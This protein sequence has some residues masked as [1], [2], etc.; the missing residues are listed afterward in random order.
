MRM[1]KVVLHRYVRLLSAHLGENLDAILLC[2]VEI[3]GY[4]M[5]GWMDKAVCLRAMPAQTA[6]CLLSAMYVVWPSVVFAE[7]YLLP[8]EG[9]NVIGEMRYVYARQE[10]TFPDIARRYNLG[11]NE[12]LHAN[13]TLD[14]WLPGE[15]T[16][17]IL[18]TRYVLPQAPRDGVIL[19][20]PEM[21]LYFFPKPMKGEPAVVITYPMSVGRMEWNTPLGKTSVV[22]KTANPAWYPP[23]SIRA[24]HAKDGDVLPQVVPPGPEN[25]LGLFALR[26]GIPGYLIHGTNRPYGVGM[27][28]THGCVRLYPEDVRSLFDKI[29]VGTPVY[30]VNQPFKAGWINDQIVF[31]AHAPLDEDM[32]T[33][34]DNKSPAVRAI[35]DTIA[36]A[37]TSIVDWDKAL[38]LVDTSSGI[39]EP[40]SMTRVSLTPSLLRPAAAIAVS[41]SARKAR[42]KTY[43][44]K[45]QLPVA[46]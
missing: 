21:R 25:P 9:G 10:D 43:E 1:S 45:T 19:N 6:R 22:N 12:L 31:E 34:G 46:P 38:S 3:S 7:T 4:I 33:R 27:R 20:V 14:P 18:P 30:I 24:E 37:G 44:P 41:G 32:A 13:P 16:K 2:K 11:F 15:G 5:Q 36:E 23:Q 29:D 42:N 28:V 8:A 40:I 17:V 35:V 39:P 26:L